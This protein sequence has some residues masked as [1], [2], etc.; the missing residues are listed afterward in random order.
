M[1]QKHPCASIPLRTKIPNDERRRAALRRAYT[2]R[3][4]QWLAPYFGRDR[5]QDLTRVSPQLILLMAL[6]INRSTETAWTIGW[7]TRS[8]RSMTAWLKRTSRGASRE[9]KDAKTREQGVWAYLEQASL[10]EV[11]LRWRKHRLGAMRN[12]RSLVNDWR[13]AWVLW[14]G[15]YPTEFVVRSIYNGL[16]RWP[17]IWTKTRDGRRNRK[18]LAHVIGVFRRGE[19]TSDEQTLQAELLWRGKK[20]HSMVWPGNTAVPAVMSARPCHR[21]KWAKGR[22]TPVTYVYPGQDLFTSS[23]IH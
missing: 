14:M 23:I 7:V 21:P 15:D 2:G 20:G 8:R 22:A 4:T 12:S 6:W 13:Q 3:F 1:F 9:P 18:S 5:I 17:G 11:F 10:G 16:K 19:L